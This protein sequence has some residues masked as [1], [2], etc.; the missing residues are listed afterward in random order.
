MEERERRVLGQASL[1]IASSIFT[2]QEVAEQL[3]LDVQ[4]RASKVRDQGV[5]AYTQP[6]A[7]TQN[8]NK[9]FLL[10][11][12][13]SVDT[14]NQRQEVDACYR[15]RQL[16]KRLH[17]DSRSH[18]R[19]DSRKRSRSNERPVSRDMKETRTSEDHDNEREFWA[20]RKALKTQA[21]LDQVGERVC[22]LENAPGYD[23][24]S[25]DELA[26]K[27]QKK[28]AKKAKKATKKLKKKHKAQKK[29]A[30]N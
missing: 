11:T 28:L 18:R 14:H 7:P 17:A 16:E 2:D 25:P 4:K 1:Q 22:S 21:I 6:M 9:G 20:A 5:F 8:I 3:R 26:K 23:S 24:S 19:H 29:Q 27:K 10:N 30:L 15:K 13:K 12:I